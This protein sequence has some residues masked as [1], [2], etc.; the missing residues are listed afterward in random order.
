MPAP[1]FEET[2]RQVRHPQALVIRSLLIYIDKVLDHQLTRE[3]KGL[4]CSHLHF[5]EMPADDKDALLEFIV[6]RSFYRSL[7]KDTSQDD[8]LQQRITSLKNKLERSQAPANAKA[9]SLVYRNWL[10]EKRKWQDE[11]TLLRTIE[12]TQKGLRSDTILNILNN[13]LSTLEDSLYVMTLDEL[14][15]GTKR[16]Y[17]LLNTELPINGLFGRLK[18]VD[19]IKAIRQIILFDCD[20]KRAFNTYS[21]NTLEGLITRGFPIKDLIVLSFDKR[22]FRLRNLINRLNMTYKRY[23]QPPQKALSY[24]YTHVIE[25]ED[26]VSPV[27]WIGDRSE[28]FMDYLDLVLGY[29]LGRLRSPSILSNYAAALDQQFAKALIADLFGEDIRHG[30]FDAETRSCI[31][32]LTPHDKRILKEAIDG[33]LQLVVSEWERI[34]EELRKYEG[35]GTV[36][37]VIPFTLANSPLFRK[38]LRSVLPNINVNLYTWKDIRDKECKDKIIYILAYRDAGRYPFDLYPSLLEK[39]INRQ[40]TFEPL[41]LRMFFGDRYDRNLFSYY[42]VKT[43]VLGD[44]FRYEFLDWKKVEARI[45]DMRPLHREEV[46]EE[47]DDDDELIDAAENIKIDYADESHVTLYPSRPVLI[48]YEEGGRLSVARADDLPEEAD[49]WEVQP[50]DELYEDLNLFQITPGEEKELELIKEGYDV[51]NLSHALWK[52]LLVRRLAAGKD[53]RALYE[54]IENVLGEK[55]FVKFEH[56]R[57]HW[58]DVDS[59]LLIPRRRRHFRLICEFLGL[60]PA[61]YRLKLK[62]RSSMTHNSRQSNWKMNALLSQMINEGLFEPGFDWTVRTLEHLMDAHGLEEKGITED[63]LV[64]ELRSLVHLI[65]EQVRLKK[66]QNIETT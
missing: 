64:N 14:D 24:R 11:L 61:Y 4:R 41:L 30:L 19:R 23:F 65:Q 13:D 34:K 46:A 26:S 62:K 9:A 12:P 31:D 27:H 20:G 32:T 51:P 35:K 39:G 47:E 49:Q 15:T 48:R 54:D 43:Q 44:A 21:G 42:Q 1:G 16:A 55:G 45:N 50:L 52:T 3:E 2:F 29:D 37:I 40:L 5:P 7:D 60:R 6:I 53:K 58:L 28:I 63:N 22:P 38:G 10:A 66:V 33:L 18:D 59:E 56:F 25:E 57:D 36:G 8:Y 17:T